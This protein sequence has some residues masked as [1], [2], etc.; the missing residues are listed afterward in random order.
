MERHRKRH[1]LPLAIVLVSVGVLVCTLAVARC[2]RSK[3][4]GEHQEASASAGRDGAPG[5]W[6]TAPAWA[7]PS[8]MEV[9]TSRLSVSEEGA[10]MLDL[11][12]Q[13][14]DCILASWGYLDMLGN[15]WSCV[16]DGGSWSDV[17]ILKALPDSGGCE[18]RV[19]HIEA[20]EL[21]QSWLSSGGGET[22]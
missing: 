18:V 5:T 2:A 15:V 14:G 10:R 1:Q 9:R 11:Y 7:I 8:G 16:V 13:R 17:C 22:W 3:G 6:A 21:E 20:D 19:M 12:E 4:R